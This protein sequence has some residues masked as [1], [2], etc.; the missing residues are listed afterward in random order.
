MLRKT[1]AT[2]VAPSRAASAAAVQTARTAQGN[3]RV[4]GAV[5][6]LEITNG[7]ASAGGSAGPARGVC[8]YAYVAAL[9]PELECRVDLGVAKVQLCGELRRRGDAKG[10]HGLSDVA[11][12]HMLLSMTSGLY[13]VIPSTF[14]TIP[15]TSSK[16]TAIDV[17]TSCGPV[18]IW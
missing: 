16:P 4:R 17:S 6:S 3:R 18:P 1:E 5:F 13:T 7:A 2:R 14:S 12:Y 9:H 10:L 8:A 15:V 11:Q